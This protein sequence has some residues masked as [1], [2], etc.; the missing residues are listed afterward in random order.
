[1]HAHL[2]VVPVDAADWSVPPFVA[3]IREDGRHGAVLYGRGA[4]DMK[5]FAGTVV[6][7]A[8]ALARSD[9]IPAT[10]SDDAGR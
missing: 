9:T 8:R 7:V 1:V 5:G 4:V 2:D 10:A 3:E 6:A